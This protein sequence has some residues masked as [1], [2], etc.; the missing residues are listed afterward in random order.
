MFDIGFIN[1]MLE[2]YGGPSD[3]LHYYGTIDTQTI[4]KKQ[5]AT[6]SYRLNALCHR[7]GVEN[8][9]AHSAMSD[10]EA[11]IELFRKL[12]DEFSLS[13]QTVIIPATNGA[14]KKRMIKRRSQKNALATASLI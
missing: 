6:A 1:A 2:R 4:A 13:V 11:N 12:R 10:V 14:A 3:K 8:V 5:M 7:F 9:K